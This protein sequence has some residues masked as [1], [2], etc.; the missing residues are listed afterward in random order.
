MSKSK[1][2]R[3]K[4]TPKY[5][6]KN[7]MRT[8]FGGLSGEHAE[9]L[10]VINLRNHGALAV[11]MQGTAGRDEFDRLTGAINMGNVMCEQGIGNE[12]RAAIIAGRDALISIGKR[13]LMIDKFV[14]TGDEM[15]VLNEAFACHDAQLENVRAIDVERAACEVERRVRCHINSTSV[16]A[17][18]ERE[19]HAAD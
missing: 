16:R 4:H 11:L 7:P 5:I 12:F 19:Q 6:S 17:E 15:Q 13:Y 2:P 1:K 18:L 8:V 14:P 9:H 10:Q 3:K